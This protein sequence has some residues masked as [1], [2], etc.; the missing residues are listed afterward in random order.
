MKMYVAYEQGV[1]RHITVAFGESLDS[2]YPKILEYFENNDEYHDIEV[3]ILD[4]DVGTVEDCTTFSQKISYGHTYIED[5][6]V[7]RYN[8][9]KH[10]VKHGIC[11]ILKDGEIFDTY[12]YEHQL[13]KKETWVE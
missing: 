5:G 6:N 13:R 3:E 12:T 11:T 1:Y 7:L 2:I 8:F 10:K 4:T 9:Y